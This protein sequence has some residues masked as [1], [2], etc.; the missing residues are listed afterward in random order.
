[1]AYVP[2]FTNDIFVSY[3][4]FDNQAV[5]G[6]VGWVAQFHQRLQ[7]EIEE[8][9]G[10][11]VAIWRDPR[12]GGADDFAK[13][14]ERHVRGSAVM[15]AVVSPGYRGSAWCEREARGF[16]GGT[17]RIDDLWVDTKCRLVKVAKR[18]TDPVLLPETMHFPFFEVDRASD[19]V[20]EL[21]ADSGKYKRLLSDVAQEIGVILRAMRKA[22][23]VF[24]G[25]ASPLLSDARDR[26]KREL[27]ARDY[28]VVTSASDH[29]LEAVRGAVRECALSVLFAGS[30]D[31]PSGSQ[32]ESL[33]T[34]E[35]TAAGE[36][37]V[38]QV[39]VARGQAG[40]DAGASGR[41]TS[42]G[43]AQNIEWLID[44]SAHTVNHTVLQALKTPARPARA[45]QLVRL[46]L[47]CDRA[48]HPLLQPNRARHLRDYFLGLGFE[49]K[50]PLAEETDAAEFSRDNRS[51]L[52]QCDGVL[53]YWG[54]SHQAWFEQRLRELMKA[55][56]WRHGREFVAVA[57]Y[58]ADPENTIKQNYHTR[59]VDHLIKQFHDFDL[60]DARLT[61]FIDSLAAGL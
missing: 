5:E 35:R 27:E 20:Y 6:A 30:A 9:L 50:L 43:D 2:G 29:A 36:E 11:R 21:E 25:T 55:R 53:L 56:G 57:G 16:V 61:R 22:R 40:H 45:Q 51:K 4:H 31:R 19:H 15:V 17:L 47:I 7:I 10:A 48:D 44:P 54:A 23:S 46:Y 38:P 41:F 42:V 58:V 14:I 33:V 34:A 39:V 8:E 12:I 32:D 37:Q 13:D 52:R 3:S 18:P 49:V 26:V 60:T 24:L 28:R 59:E 1:M